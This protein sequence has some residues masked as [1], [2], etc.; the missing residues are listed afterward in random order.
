MID[1]INPSRVERSCIRNGTRASPVNCP[2]LLSLA[3]IEPKLAICYGDFQ[4]LFLSNAAV[5]EEPNVIFWFIGQEDLSKEGLEGFLQQHWRRLWEPNKKLHFHVDPVDWR[6]EK[7][8]GDN[9]NEGNGNGVGGCGEE[10][11]GVGGDG[12]QQRRW[13]HQLVL[14]SH[15]CCHPRHPLMPQALHRRHQSLRF[16]KYHY[17]LLI[18]NYSLSSQPKACQSRTA[19]AENK[20]Q[21]STTSCRAQMQKSEGS[22][23][24]CRAQ[25]RAAELN[26]KLQRSSMKLQSS[27]TS[28]RAQPQAAEV[29]HEAAEHKHE[30]PRSSTRC[31]GRARSAELKHELP[32]STTSCRDQT[33]V[34]EHKHKLP[35]SSTKCRGRARSEE[36]KHEL[37][38]STMSC[39]TQ[40]LAAEVIDFWMKRSKNKNSKFENTGKILL[41]DRGKYQSLGYD[42]ASWCPFPSY[43]AE[44]TQRDVLD[45]SGS[46]LV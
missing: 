2:H 21:N 7:T 15:G 23:T 37:L 29:K 9:E 24:K 11:H 16:P 43:W 40:T 13:S 45:I 26:H 27:N 14:R 33:Q 34:A 35:R 25:T 20:V 42:F 30:L 31:R 3:V 28:C 4:E 39:R 44:Q 10:R 12:I 41:L 46:A 19:K 6:E 32:S 18:K 5:N 36:L 17:P 38:R 8:I 22:S 1:G